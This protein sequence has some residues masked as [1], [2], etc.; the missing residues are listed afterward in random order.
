M[1]TADGT[2]GQTPYLWHDIFALSSL[3]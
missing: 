1:A 3:L 2:W